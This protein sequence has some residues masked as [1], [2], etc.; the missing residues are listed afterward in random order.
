MYFRCLHMISSSQTASQGPLEYTKKAL[1]SFMPARQSPMVCSSSCG[2]L[3]L[4]SSIRIDSAMLNRFQRLALKYYNPRTWQ[5]EFPDYSL[6][7][8][9]EILESMERCERSVEWFILLRAYSIPSDGAICIF[10]PSRRT[11]TMKMGTAK[12]GQDLDFV[13]RRSSVSLSQ[14][15]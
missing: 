9:R 15:T 10:R 2:V 4:S 6:Q 14:L 1:M 12:A 13:V 11:P 8:E 5:A 3:V 7:F